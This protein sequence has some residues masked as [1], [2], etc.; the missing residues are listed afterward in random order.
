MND[1]MVNGVRLVQVAPPDGNY[2]TSEELD[3]YDLDHLPVGTKA[4]WYWYTTAPYEGDGYALIEL[5]SGEWLM[6]YMGHCSCYG[7]LEHISEASRWPSIEAFVAGITDEYRESV[8]PIL[9]AIRAE[10]KA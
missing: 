7:P 5:M 1:K 8:R 3:D 2:G 9:E 4:V 6:H 10:A